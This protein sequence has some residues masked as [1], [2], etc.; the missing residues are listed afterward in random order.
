MRKIVVTLIEGASSKHIEEA[1][2]VQ[3]VTVSDVIN[4]GAV[5]NRA[6]LPLPEQTHGKSLAQSTWR[7]AVIIPRQEVNAFNAVDIPY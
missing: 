5:V 7:S 2:R 4:I 1:Q 3:Y 6:A